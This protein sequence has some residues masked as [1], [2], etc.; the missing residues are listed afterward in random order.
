MGEYLVREGA[1]SAA[2]VIETLVG[3]V[4]D[5][6]AVVLAIMLIEPL[7]ELMLGTLSLVT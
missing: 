6:A 7:S 5:D 4:S 3:S 1:G 2:C